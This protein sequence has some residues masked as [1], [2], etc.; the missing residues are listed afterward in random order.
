[1]QPYRKLKAEM[2]LKDIKHQDIADFLNINKSTFSNK[3]NRVNGNDFKPDEIKKMCERYGF[4][5][6]IFFDV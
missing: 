5:L 6:D 1:M 2:I 3:I 4:G